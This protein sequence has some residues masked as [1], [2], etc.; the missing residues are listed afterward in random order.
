MSKFL[1]S[2]VGPTGIG[3]TKLSLKLATYFKTEIISADSRQFFKEIPIGTASP[4][5]LELKKI[6]HNFIHH[7][8]I[9]ENYNVGEF[10]KDAIRRIETLYKKHS[11]LYYFYNHF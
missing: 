8:S 4:S 10:E 1:I 3:K 11:I 2:I 5:A 6:P 7:K 9:T